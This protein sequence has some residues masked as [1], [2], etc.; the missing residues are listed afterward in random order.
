MM[1][2]LIETGITSKDA[3]KIIGVHSFVGQKAVVQSKRL[4]YPVLKEILKKSIEID[5]KSKSSSVARIPRF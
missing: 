3:S 4:S 1:K 5:R 2:S